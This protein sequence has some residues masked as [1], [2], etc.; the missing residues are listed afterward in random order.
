LSHTL[1]FSK[2][3]NAGNRRRRRNRRRQQSQARPRGRSAVNSWPKTRKI[4]MTGAEL[5]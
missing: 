3:T 1:D 2:F 5:D 4:A